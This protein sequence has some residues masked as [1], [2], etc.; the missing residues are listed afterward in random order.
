MPTERSDERRGGGYLESLTRIGSEL[1]GHGTSK[2]AR[3]QFIHLHLPKDMGMLRPKDN[4]EHLGNTMLLS[5]GPNHLL[6]FP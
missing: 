2:N 1:I 3:Y 5:I 4:Q 6:E